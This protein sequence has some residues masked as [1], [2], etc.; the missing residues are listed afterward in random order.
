MEKNST[1]DVLTFLTWEKSVLG[2]V[3]VIIIITSIYGNCGLLFVLYQ[4]D[5]MWTSTYLLIGNLATA[6]LLISLL[7]MPF[8]LAAVVEGDWPVDGAAG[9]VLCTSVGFVN[10]LLFHATIFTHTMISFGKYFAVVKPFSRVMT[11]KRTKYILELTWLLAV[12]ISVGPLFNFGTFSFGRTTLACGIT[13]PHHKAGVVYLLILFIVAYVLPIIIMVF[14]YLNVCMSV[15]QHSKRLATTCSCENVVSLQKKLVLTSIFSLICFLLCWSPF[16][17]FVLMSVQLHSNKELP[18]ALGISAYWCGFS[19]NSINPLVIG[20]MNSRFG[21]GLRDIT[22]NLFFPLVQ[23]WIRVKRHF[24]RKYAVQ[25]QMEMQNVVTSPAPPVYAATKD[26]RNG[27]AVTGSNGL[28]GV[29]PDT[30]QM[31]NLALSSSVCSKLN[32]LR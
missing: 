7:S 16:C 20:T 32:L 27:S 28:L 21:E 10:S 30:A 4:N 24:C 25:K 31:G 17:V 2:V 15:K 6:S 8:S 13:F 9:E 12:I 11:M 5:K 1:V 14:V 22:C 23:C 3:L 18:H 26:V 19:Y 29:P